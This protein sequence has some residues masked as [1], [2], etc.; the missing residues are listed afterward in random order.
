MYIYV[1][2]FII[3]YEYY[4][5]CYYCKMKTILRSFLDSKTVFLP[6]AKHT[7]LSCIILSQ[8]CY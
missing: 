8:A 3:L 1:Y 6:V 7:F 4:K 2:R 5:F